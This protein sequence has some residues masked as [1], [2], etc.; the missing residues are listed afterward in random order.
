[1]W[2]TSVFII[3]LCISNLW[4]FAQ[5]FAVSGKVFDSES[6]QPL[7]FVNII[8]NNSN[9]GTATDI[10]G[11]FKIYSN[12][13]IGFL[14][15]SYVGYEPLTFYLHGKNNNVEIRLNKTSVE[16]EEVVIVAGENPAH[17]I[18]KNVVENR[19]NNNPEKLPS[20][21]Y[22]SY[23]KM[24]FTVDSIDSNEEVDTRDSGYIR[25][26]NFLSDKD[27]FMMETVSERKFMLPDRNH[28]K[29]L[30]SRI[31]GFK[32]PVFLFLISQLQSSTFYNELITISDKKYINPISKGSMRKYFFQIEDTT[33]TARGDSV[34]II[35]FRPRINTNFDGLK[36]VLSINNHRW[37]IQ[38]VI[39]EPSREKEGIAIKIQ[40]MYQ[41]VNDSTWFPVQLNT[42]I[43]FHSIS[44]NNFVPVGRGR[45]YIK[46][47]E[48][49]PDLV[50]RQFNQISVEFDPIAG[51][52][53][54]DF[55]L[56]YRGDSLTNREQRT[57]Q[58]V[59]SIGKK[60]NLDK[61]V[62]GIKTLLNNRLPLGKIDIDLTK[63]A[64][65][66]DY[67]GLYLGMGLLT[68]KKLSQTFEAGAFW[69]YGFGDKTAKYGGNLSVT[70][71]RYREIKVGLAYFDYVT[72]TGGVKFYGDNESVL[73]PANFRSLLITQMDRTER[74]QAA[75]SFRG[76]RYGSF[77][78][79]MAK[80]LKRITNNYYFDP[81]NTGS[82]VEKP[83][84]NFTEFSAGLRYAYKEKFLDLHDTRISLGTKFPVVWFK[85]TRGLSGMLEGDFAYNKFDLKIEKTFFLK[86]FG[87]SKFEFMAG[88]V[89]NPIPQTN[90][91]SG[92]GAYHAFTIYA[93]GSFATQRMNEFLANKYAFLFYTHNFG[94]LLWRGKKFS[95]EFAIA[96]NLGIGDL[97]HPEYHKGITYK[98][99]DQ[100]YFESG[101]LINSMLNMSGIYTIGAGLF[102][103]YGFYHLP[104][105]ADNFA[106]K[107]TITFP[108]IF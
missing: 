58:F 99:M 57:Y 92:R 71:N 3:I 106:Y 14:R 68:S 35:S 34:F 80:D 50:K 60:E 19:D 25:L 46:N 100:G 45:S 36:G 107:I 66:N 73:N 88:Y 93:P 33:Y 26:K 12:Q 62:Y 23:D 91:Y 15:L 16:L 82:Q 41:L 7:A 98:V 53:S 61:M 78:I 8:T 85:Y 32:D 40:Q 67:E 64:K 39:A 76:L 102:Y 43:I 10:D 65:Y 90:L 52:R 103:R 86:Y 74:M 4:A 97:D 75:V 11:K 31:S 96:T 37:A 59:D 1:M 13:E 54:E 27:F 29:V 17:R 104:K 105:T 42:D 63:I 21:A 2:K 30:A 101:L 83:E 84:Y 22:T 79:G 95:P 69:G 72:E 18:I 9:I 49:N 87:E 94:K 108:L 81:E 51:N 70:I 28:E 24:I 56:A 48:V 38:N 20:F 47:I 6:G 89:D 77:T 5:N 44:V 55:W